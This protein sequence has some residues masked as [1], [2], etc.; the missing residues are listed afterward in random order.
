MAIGAL[1]SGAS[2]LQGVYRSRITVVLAVGVGMAVAS[3]FGALTAPWIPLLVLITGIVGYAW[4]IVAQ[5]G[6]PARVAALNTTVAFIIFSSL[7][8]APQQDAIQSLLLFCGA[9]IQALLLLLSWPLDRWTIERRALAAV[10]RDVA[11]VAQAM[12]SAENTFPAIASF[13]RAR[14]ILD[15]PQPFSSSRSVARM[16]RLLTDA[17]TLRSRFG[18]L[19]AVS[20]DELVPENRALAQAVAGQ[21]TTLAQ[22]LER[23]TD[24]F[25]GR[26]PEALEAEFRAYETLCEHQHPL[27]LSVARDIAAALRDATRLV[28]VVATGR[29]AQFLFSAMP[30]PRDYIETRVHWIN[31]DAVRNAVTLTIAMA[32][33]HTLF[34]AERGYW[35]ALTAA[36]VLRPDLHSTL[37]RGAAR[38]LGTLAG[39]VLATIAAA[40][41]HGNLPLEA[42]TMIAAAAIAYLTLVPNYAIF[43][44]VITVFV[45]IALQ[46][47]GA[48]GNATVVDRVLDTLV[49]GALAMGG[50]VA[51]PSW[52][53]QRTRPLL[54]ELL[55]AQRRFAVLLIN[56]YLEPQRDRS[57]EISEIRTR[58]WKLR[59]EVEAAVDR[60]RLE[61]K[62]PHTIS[63]DSALQALAASQS[64]AL[65]NMTLEAGLGELRGR[66][67]PPSLPSFRDALD[68]RLAKLAA[69]YRDGRPPEPEPALNGAYERLAAEASA[70]VPVRFVVESS[71][72]YMRAAEDLDRLAR[73][74]FGGSASA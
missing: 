61:P 60:S 54:A 42:A 25:A 1:V 7:P 20:E 4:G 3:F 63:I 22:T 66:A 71:A 2:S 53:Y 50:Y 73:A 72:D 33:S 13:G 35:I 62:R 48:G 34:S 59:T 37:V 64:F 46:L 28:M 29:P 27:A 68:A 23:G 14:R 15:D 44:A 36:L 24:G 67:L 41:T 38:M 65:T 26:L 57:R 16:K 10:Y 18:A 9:A 74:A 30:R 55:D 69:A 47:V 11:A 56:A 31:R 45:V 19:L 5:F 17:E 21:L 12:A 6:M 52:G 39:A 51:L 43:S 58:C 8:L 49:G 40:L 70:F 32:L